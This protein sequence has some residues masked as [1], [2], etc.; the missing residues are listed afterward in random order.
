MS[1]DAA[2]PELG[3]LARGGI[4]VPARDGI[5]CLI[6]S[7]YEMVYLQ[8]ARLVSAAQHV[9]LLDKPH[10]SSCTLLRQNH[11][12]SSREPATATERQCTAS[13]V[14]HTSRQGAAWPTVAFATPAGSQLSLAAQPSW[15]HAEQAAA[16][17]SRNAAHQLRL[18]ACRRQAQVPGRRDA[19]I[20]ALVKAPL[21]ILPRHVLPCEPVVHACAAASHFSCAEGLGPLE[22][23]CPTTAHM[24]K[25]Q[26]LQECLSLGHPGNGRLTPGKW[27]SLGKASLPV[28]CSIVQQTLS[29]SPERSW[30]SVHGHTAHRLC[31][32]AC[33]ATPAWPRVHG[34]RPE[35][36]ATAAPPYV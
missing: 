33:R 26:Q 22:E 11:H 36:E 28:A 6:Q 16:C 2:I 7:A 34:H 27:L 35:M 5:S 21:P 13:Q 20:G 17:M 14:P 10:C 15:A 9:L 30:S 18:D 3:C 32:A 24:A 25:L 31:R 23:P 8:A 4:L 1:A 19:R 12:V 29:V